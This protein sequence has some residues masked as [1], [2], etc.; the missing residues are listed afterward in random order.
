MKKKYL[1][2]FIIPLLFLFASCS[3]DSFKIELDKNWSYSITGMDGEYKPIDNKSFSKLAS[4]LPGRKGHIFLKTT[5]YIPEEYKQETLKCFL[6]NIKIANDFFFNGNHLGRNGFFEPNPFSIGGRC[7]SYSLPPPLSNYNDVPNEIIVHIYCDGEGQMDIEPFIGLQ[8][9]IKRYEN[10]VD[11][12]NSKLQLT[13]SILLFFVGIIYLFLYSLRRSDKSNLS[14]GLL[15]IF[16]SLFLVVFCLGEYPIIFT[17]NYSYLLFQKLFR[18]ISA[19][20]STYFAVSFIRDFLGMTDSFSRKIYRTAITAGPCIFILFTQNMH[21]F[22]ICLGITYILICVHIFYAVKL[23]I[24]AIKNKNKKLPVLIAGFSPVLISILVCIFLLIINKSF[25]SIIIILGWQLVILSF[26][27]ILLRD[28]ANMSTEVEY[29][30]ANL[31]NLVQ[32]RTEEL[33]KSN[34]ALEEMNTHLKFEKERADKEIELASYVQQSFY[35]IQLPEF[36]NFEIAYY[37]KP[38]AGVSGDLFDFYYEKDVLNGFGIF[39]VSGHGIS[40]GLVTMLVKNIIQQEFD[41]SPEIIPIN[42]LKYIKISRTD[43]DPNLVFYAPVSNIKNTLSSIIEG[44]EK[45]N[46]DIFCEYIYL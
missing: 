28:F 20:V 3:K 19:S 42:F 39:D 24:I 30:N 35:N 26:L 36:K 22:F 8:D 21:D 45:N 18:G 43:I 2:T 15:N 46:V 34:S 31:E 10:R 12:I 25:S 40:S 5:F 37:N 6:G 13:C 4:F 27:C 23:I 29:L 7:S 41:N 1:F 16:S 32:N 38:M 17:N 14:F 44:I 11:F 33:T 9:N